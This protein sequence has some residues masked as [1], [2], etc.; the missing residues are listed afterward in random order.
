MISILRDARWGLRLLGRNPG[1]TAVALIALTLG[2]GANAAIFSVVHATLIAPLPFEDP[3]RI[4]I[5]WSRVQNRR[6]STSAG[7]FME[8]RR[9]S[10]S[11]DALHVW[12]GRRVSLSSS[13][14]PELVQARVATPGFLTAHGF[15]MS[16]GRD[17]RPR[18]R[19]HRERSG[20]RHDASSLADAV[21]G[22][23]ADHQSR[24][25]GR[26]KTVHGGGRLAPG[27]ADRL[28]SQLFLPLAFTPEQLNHDFH[29]LLVLGRLKQDV[30]LAQANA[31]MVAVAKRIAEAHPR[32]PIRAGARASSRCRTT[33]STRT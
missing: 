2:V 31:D 16:L 7:D 5:V 19:R 17:L 15:K 13:G 14:P 12:T 32:S 30:T 22:R 28:E 4:V 1:F 3:D 23:S 6:N 26:R 9:Q 10:K 20:D 11:F 8:W 18:R 24:H 29:W 27:A 21:R 33:S 25:Q